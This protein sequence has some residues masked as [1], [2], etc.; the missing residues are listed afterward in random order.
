MEDDDSG[1]K[2]I[3]HPNLHNPELDSKNISS[4]NQLFSESP[5]QGVCIPQAPIHYI[6]AF[7]LFFFFGF[8]HGLFLLAFYPNLFVAR[9]KSN[10]NL[11]RKKSVCLWILAYIVNI[12]IFFFFRQTMLPWYIDCSGGEVMSPSCLFKEQET[13]YAV[14]YVIHLVLLLLALGMWIYHGVKLGCWIYF[15]RK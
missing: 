11:V 6:F 5:N 15:V 14:F 4:E 8:T 12:L 3:D 9:T 10:Q 2:L 13:R 1:V 7:F